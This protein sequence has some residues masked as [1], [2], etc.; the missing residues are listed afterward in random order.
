MS[1]WKVL[2]INKSHHLTP[3]QK[4]I[5]VDWANLKT[6]TYL[7]RGIVKKMSRKLINAQECFTRSI[8]QIATERAKVSTGRQSSEA[9]R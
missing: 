9:I 7:N 4:L 3:L 2:Q 5:E 8:T 1:S 6:V